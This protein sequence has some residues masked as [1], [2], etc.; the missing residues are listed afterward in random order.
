MRDEGR[1]SEERKTLGRRSEMRRN[2]EK[3]NQGAGMK[4]GIN[5]YRGR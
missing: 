4:G 2:K 1:K 3:M 5:F